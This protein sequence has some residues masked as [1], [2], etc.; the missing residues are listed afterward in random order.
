MIW[1]AFCAIAA[2]ISVVAMFCDNFITDTLF[3]GR[4]AQGQ[5]VFYGPAYLVTCL[6]MFF[7]FPIQNV[8]LETIGLLVLSGLINTV[9][10]IFYYTA[11]SKDDTNNVTLFEQLAPLFYLVFGR[12][13]LG[14]HI[15]IGQLIAFLIVLAAPI[16]IVLTSRKRSKKAKLC[17]AGFVALEVSIAAL[18]HTLAAKGGVGLDPA[19][20]LFYVMLGK[21]IG[22]T[23]E[24][25]VMKSWRHRFFNVLKATKKKR[26]FWIPFT[27]DHFLYLAYDALY[28]SAMLMAPTIAIVPAVV[29]SAKPLLVFLFGVVFSILWPSFGREKINK[30][31][32]SIRLVATGLAVAGVTLMQ[33]LS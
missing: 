30:K 5:K 20:L 21:G 14:E 11:M 12:F 17:T 24:I 22:D 27:A 10:S 29:K 23:V 7:I 26:H 15:S 18:G 2:A 4:H 3:K 33:V 32:I 28:Y 31:S 6:A 8:P 16:I 25:L 13:I 9:G 1:I 19:T